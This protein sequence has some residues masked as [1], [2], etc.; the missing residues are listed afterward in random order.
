MIQTVLWCNEYII[1]GNV[2]SSKTHLNTKFRLINNLIIVNSVAW[3][4]WKCIFGENISIIPYH[5]IFAH[6]HAMNYTWKSVKLF[7]LDVNTFSSES[8]LHNSLVYVD[9]YNLKKIHFHLP[10]KIIM[11]NRDIFF[12]LYFISTGNWI[13]NFRSF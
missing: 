7:T 4:V 10:W 1:F 2:M 8:I 6:S 9:V 13:T 3:F 11:W 12:I 5:Q